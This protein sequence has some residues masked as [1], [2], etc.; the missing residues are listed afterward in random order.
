MD[1]ISSRPCL[2]SSRRGDRVGL[3]GPVSES[4]SVGLMTNP[5]EIPVMN[6]NAMISLLADSVRD[7]GRGGW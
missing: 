4:G 3:S 1:S 5:V 7:P 2:G 6:W